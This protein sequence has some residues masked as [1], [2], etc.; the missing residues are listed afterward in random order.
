MWLRKNNQKRNFVTNKDRATSRASVSNQEDRKVP[1]NNGS[2]RPNK[3]SNKVN[4]DSVANDTE[5]ELQSS[6]MK[7][8]SKKK[9][10]VHKDVPFEKILAKNVLINKQERSERYNIASGGCMNLGAV[11]RKSSMDVISFTFTSPIKR[12]MPGV[13]PSCLDIEKNNHLS[14]GSCHGYDTHDL[15]RLSS[16][17]LSVIGGDALNVLLDEKL[18]ELTCKVETSANNFVE[19]ESTAYSSFSLQDSFPNQNVINTVSSEIENSCQLNWH[20]DQSSC[21]Y[22]C[23]SVDNLWLKAKQKYQVSVL[24]LQFHLHPLILSFV[25]HKLIFSSRRG[26]KLII[27]LFISGNCS[28]FV[29]RSSQ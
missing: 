4:G 6:K 12:S 9:H 11:D 13:L 17:G 8:F 27:F 19:V 1:A 29:V 20:E 21:P 3:A 28:N 2:L 25:L 18:K 7:T 10:S 16:L 22:D 24:F 5:K 23:S 26:H 14:S 15:K